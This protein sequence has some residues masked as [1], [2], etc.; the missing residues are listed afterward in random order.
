MRSVSESSGRRRKTRSAAEALAQTRMHGPHSR[1]TRDTARVSDPEAVAV[2]MGGLSVTLAA[3]NAPSRGPWFDWGPRREAQG[4]CGGRRYRLRQSDVSPTER[5]VVNNTQHGTGYHR[6]PPKRGH[7]GPRNGDWKQKESN[8]REPK[9]A[10]ELG[11]T[12]P[13][14][15]TAQHSLSTF[16]PKQHECATSA[17]WIH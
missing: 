14:N 11:R 5:L 3:L 17:V 7:A 13:S 12:Q 6:R 10:R 9:I 4:E 16:C 8:T 2:V 15:Y 1:K